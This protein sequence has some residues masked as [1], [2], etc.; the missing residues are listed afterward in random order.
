MPQVRR[1]G[2]DEVV[3]LRHVVLRDGL[4]RCEA[5]FPG[6]ESP[7]SRHYGAFENSRLVGCV[8]LHVSAW[9]HNPAWHLRGMAVAADARSLGI[10]RSMIEMM[11]RDLDDSPIRQL[12][13]NARV[14]ASGFYEKLGWQIVSGQFEIPTA[15]PHVRMTRKLGP[16]PMR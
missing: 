5:I 3:D 11:E 14:P 13:C 10:G 4:P 8:T 1:V 7:S 9:E 16:I 2:L 15:G 12:W 6:D